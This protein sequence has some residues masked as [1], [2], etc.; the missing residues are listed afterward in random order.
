MVST[1]SHDVNSI[2]NIIFYNFWHLLRFSIII[3]Q[4]SCIYHPGEWFGWIHLTL[5]SYYLRLE[6]VYPF[7]VAIAP[8][9]ALSEKF[10]PTPEFAYLTV[11][12]SCRRN[13]WLSGRLEGAYANELPVEM[14]GE[15]FLDTFDDHN[16][17][18]TRVDPRQ[19][20]AVKAPAAHPVLE[21]FR[22]KVHNQ[23]LLCLKSLL[24]IF[25]C[26]VSFFS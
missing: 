26:V 14:K 19:T 18:V 9:S 20:Y 13:L 1:L 15:D 23:I 21:D 6:I 8:W 2:F 16:D 24:V 5:V 17:P 4:G 25:L 22:V 10:N 11:V 12:A 7:S 3:Y